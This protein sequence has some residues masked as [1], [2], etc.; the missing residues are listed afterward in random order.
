MNCTAIQI[1]L[2]ALLDG[3]LAPETSAAVEAHLASCVVCSQLR[4]EMTAVMAAASLWHV[5]GH[6]LVGSLLQRIDNDERHSLL[7]E[8]KRLR[9]EIHSLR[10]EVANLTSLTNKRDAVHKRDF[11]VLQ[12][13]YV[14]EK[15]HTDGFH[16][17]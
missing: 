17:L 5:Q 15:Q 10:V 2:P 8:V 16:A 14:H 9:E 4:G 1:Q 11:S 13:P 7:L 3:E 6:D 12:F